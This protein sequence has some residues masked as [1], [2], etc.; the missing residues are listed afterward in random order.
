LGRAIVRQ[1]AAFLFV[2]P[3]SHNDAQLRVEMRRELKRLRH[4]LWGTLVY[5]TH[6][7]AMARV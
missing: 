6:D 7:Q 1:P 2:E 3:F 4:R 5:V